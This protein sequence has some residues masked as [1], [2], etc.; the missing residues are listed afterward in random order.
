MDD[1]EERGGVEP[2]SHR[3]PDKKKGIYTYVYVVVV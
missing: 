1:V 3:S 2:A